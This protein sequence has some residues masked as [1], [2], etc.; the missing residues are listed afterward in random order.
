MPSSRVL[1][2]RSQSIRK[3][4]QHMHLHDGFAET[5]AVCTRTFGTPKENEY[6]KRME[7]THLAP[8]YRIQG[9]HPLGLLHSNTCAGFLASEVV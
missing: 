2:H 4:T 6:D 7:D 1:V 9:I 8:P 5:L 3:L